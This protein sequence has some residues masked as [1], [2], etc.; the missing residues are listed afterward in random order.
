M[1]IWTKVHIK[2]YDKN[3]FNLAKSIT[4]YLYSYGPINN[5]SSKYN[6]SLEDRKMLD[7]HTAKRIAGLLMLYLSKDTKRI[8]D[9]A[10]KYNVDNS[11]INDLLPEI[12]GYIDK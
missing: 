9:I 10:N 4:N 7:Q 8:N 11:N 1:K 3:V 6:I 5:I 12:E 2:K